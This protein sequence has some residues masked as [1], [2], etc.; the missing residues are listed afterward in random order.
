[1]PEKIAYL[2]GD[3]L[4]G[5]LN[6]RVV[7][8]YH[9]DS[10]TLEAYFIKGVMHGVARLFDE[11]EALFYTGLYQNGLP[12]GPFWF[13]YQ[14]SNKFV[15]AHF[16]NGEIVKKNVTLI[17]YSKNTGKSLTAS[18][19]QSPKTNKLIFLWRFHLHCL[20]KTSDKEIL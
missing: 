17:D 11:N 9:D 6:G 10:T 13:Y 4:K 14:M 1:M 16:E 19:V 3:F 2:V 7:M 12:N 5:K 20:A 18:N 15:Y 8:K